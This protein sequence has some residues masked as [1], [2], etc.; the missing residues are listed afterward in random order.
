MEYVAKLWE[1]ESFAQWIAQNRTVIRVWNPVGTGLASPVGV[2][3][4]GLQ[5]ALIFLG[6]DFGVFFLRDDF[7][8]HWRFVIL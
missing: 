6:G 5:V 2:I 8:T 3:A 1:S 4:I 7:L